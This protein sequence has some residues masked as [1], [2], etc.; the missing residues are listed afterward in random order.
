MTESRPK[1]RFGC[2]HIPRD[3]CMPLAAVL[4][5]SVLFRVL[6]LNP[7]DAGSWILLVI[8]VAYLACSAVHWK[9]H[10]IRRR[11]VRARWLEERL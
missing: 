8:S 10:K 6:E 2:R 7:W 11:R 1:K 4:A 3:L 9:A 5:Y